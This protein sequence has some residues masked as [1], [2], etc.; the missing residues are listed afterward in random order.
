MTFKRAT[1]FL[2]QERPS[3]A[4]SRLGTLLSALTTALREAKRPSQRNHAE[5]V[6]DTP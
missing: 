5:L 3:L 1:H 4:T 2:L 6:R